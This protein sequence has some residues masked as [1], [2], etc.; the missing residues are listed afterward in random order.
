MLCGVYVN[1]PLMCDLRCN[2][3]CINYDN[4]PIAW[5]HNDIGEVY[6]YPC[7]RIKWLY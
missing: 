3:P 5:L 6:V 2:M 4:N 1:T 7:E